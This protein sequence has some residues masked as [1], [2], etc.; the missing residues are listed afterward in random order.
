MSV[1]ARLLAFGTALA[2]LF[3][4]A[5]VVAGA[6]VP[7]STVASWEDR[8]GEDA[9]HA[10][11]HSDDQADAEAGAG[12][13]GSADHAADD[14][15]SDSDDVADPLRATGLALAADGYRLGPVRA[16]TRPREGGE[17]AF[18]VLGPDD[19]P[20]MAYD[21]THERELHLLVVREDGSGFRHVHPE[22]DSEGTWSLPWRWEQAGTYRVYVDLVPA[23]TG[24]PI[25]LSRTVQVSGPVGP[26]D[27]P[28]EATTAR[29]GPFEVRLVGD[30]RAGRESTIT[31]RVKRDGEPV[32]NLRPYLGAFG[33]LVA[34]REGDLAFLHVHPQGDVPEADASS[35]PEVA[36]RVAAPTA[37]RYHLYLD[38]RVGQRVHTVAF[39]REA[40]RPTRSTP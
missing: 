27:P 17:L 15:H 16:P 14:A 7:A 11:E 38:F 13:A 9:E 5:F 25:T 2:V 40:A 23:D 19:R 8:L 6:V 26:P 33:H 10:A 4:L 39:T 21:V 22:R 28:E 18:T 29:S 12:A 34:L 36:F 30:L 35:G 20:L 24:T 1:G 32:T 37:G 31:A 3:G